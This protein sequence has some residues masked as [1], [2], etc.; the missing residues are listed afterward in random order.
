MDSVL[1]AK[2]ETIALLK[3][4]VSTYEEMLRLKDL[5]AEILEERISR[6]SQ[7]K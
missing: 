7:A 3:E 6:L 5:H 1:Q 4:L 2:D